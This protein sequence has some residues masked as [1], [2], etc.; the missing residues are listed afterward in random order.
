MKKLKFALAALLIIALIVG[1][2]IATGSF[3]FGYEI[4]DTIESTN[5]TLEYEYIDLT[6]IEDY[7]DHKDDLKSLDN[8]AIVGT[9]LN[10][11]PG[12]VSGEVWL[13]YDSTFT[14]PD[15]VR[16]YGTRIFV[17]TGIPEDILLYINWEDG[18]GWIENFPEV[19]TAVL[20]SAYLVIYGLGDADIF[21]VELD[22]DIIFTV[23]AGL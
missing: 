22:I 20:D 15:T 12:A 3:T 10:N 18:L 4:D 21:D 19:Q 14:D 23:T 9:I 1:C 6:T 5:A 7:N 2:G 17:T 16:Y 8:V 11:G 13:A